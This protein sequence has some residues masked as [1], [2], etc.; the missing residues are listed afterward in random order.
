[1]ITKER[2]QREENELK[3]QSDLQGATT[4]KSLRPGKKKTPISNITNLVMKRENNGKGGVNFEKDAIVKRMKFLKPCGKQT[5]RDRMGGMYEN[6]EHTLLM[7]TNS[8]STK[9]LGLW[10]L[11]GLV[12]Q[13]IQ[14]MDIEAKARGEDDDMTVNVSPTGTMI[15]Q[16]LSKVTNLCWAPL[17][18]DDTS[19]RFILYTTMC[20]LGPHPSLALLRKLNPSSIEE[21]CSTEFNLGNKAAWTCAW[22]TFRQ[23]FSIGSEKNGLLIDAQTRYLWEIHA[24]GSAIISQDFSNQVS[25]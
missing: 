7:H 25:L 10:S 24:D 21:L 20:I 1:M 16:S 19:D 4:K 9:L 11:R 14:S 3:R 18:P 2:L 17:T 23:Q 5:I 12:V 13:R 15:L 6:L 22:N 8:Q